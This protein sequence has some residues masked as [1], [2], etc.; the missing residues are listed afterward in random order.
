ML[1]KNVSLDLSALQAYCIAVQ[2]CISHTPFDL[3]CPFCHMRCVRA[4]LDF[5][6]ERVAEL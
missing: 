1:F 4:A 3:K 5:L 6:A 2:L